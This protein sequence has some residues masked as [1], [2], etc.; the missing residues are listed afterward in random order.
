MVKRKMNE[1]TLKGEVSS[2]CITQIP[3]LVESFDGLIAGE[4]LEHVV[5]DRVAVNECWRI[6]RGGGICVVSVPAHPYLWGVS[7]EWAG[8]KRR[9]TKEGLIKLFKDNGFK[10]EAVFFW[11]F[12]LVR[13]YNRFVFSRWLRKHWAKETIERSNSITN[14]EMFSVLSKIL[15]MVFRLDNLFNSLPWGIGIILCA[16]KI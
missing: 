9:Y 2:G 10:I 4:V 5:D 1:S 3:F 13:L 11:G 6:L 8:H 7:D 15:F 12:P 14:R 16:R